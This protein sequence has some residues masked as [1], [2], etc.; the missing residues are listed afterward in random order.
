MLTQV[1]YP[2][3]M[4]DGHLSEGMAH[5]AGGASAGRTGRRLPFMTP[6]KIAGRL[7]PGYT[8][9]PNVQISHKH[10]PK[11]KTSTF[12][13]TW[14]SVRACICEVYLTSSIYGRFYPNVRQ[15]DTLLCM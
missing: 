6:V 7:S 14:S 10:T 8:C 5:Q 9:S 13:V 2:H 4:N 1:Q 3:D 15:A 11:E 12:S